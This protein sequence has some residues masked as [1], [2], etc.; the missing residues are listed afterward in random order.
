MFIIVCSF[1]GDILLLKIFR[2]RVSLRIMSGQ[3]VYGVHGGMGEGMAS[4]K[5][6]R[7]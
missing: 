3:S 2:M 4:N 1:L 7:I 5:V 6:P